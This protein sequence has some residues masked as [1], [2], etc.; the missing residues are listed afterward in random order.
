MNAENKE[1]ACEME[2]R[3]NQC[4]QQ[5]HERAVDTIGEMLH[6]EIASCGPDAGEYTLYASTERWMGNAFG[7][8]H[9]GMISTALDQGMGMLAACL[10]GGNAITPTIQLN[11]TFHHFLVAGEQILLK[12]QVEAVTR[13]MIHLRAEVFSRQEPERLCA[14]ST[15]IFF[16]KALS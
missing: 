7:T 16:I 14:S 1:S 11:V 12:I 9:G 6:F 3:L 13:A 4:L 8:L 2:R 15:G 5:M 10:A